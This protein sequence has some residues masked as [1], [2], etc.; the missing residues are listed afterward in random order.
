MVGKVIYQ[1]LKSLPLGFTETLQPVRVAEYVV[2]GI[3][4]GGS[5]Q[6]DPLKTKVGGLA[7]Q[8]GSYPLKN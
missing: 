2:L 4:V 5:N 8:G 7:E 3:G 1:R 6:I